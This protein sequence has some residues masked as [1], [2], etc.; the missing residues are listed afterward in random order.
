MDFGIPVIAWHN[1][2]YAYFYMNQSEALKLKQNKKI[3]YCVIFAISKK[4]DLIYLKK[5][6]QSSSVLVFQP[7]TCLVHVDFQKSISIFCRTEFVLKS[8][9]VSIRWKFLENIEI[10]G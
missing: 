3:Q 1:Y 7:R 5:I 6:L 8:L 9:V 2:F 10:S 4:L